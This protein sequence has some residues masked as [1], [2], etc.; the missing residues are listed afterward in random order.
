MKIKLN[1]AT[2]IKKVELDGKW[3]SVD[4]VIDVDDKDGKVLLNTIYAGV[5]KF[6]KDVEV[7]PKLVKKEEAEV[8]SDKDE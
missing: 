3:Y 6:V 8:K 1:K 7:Q 4:D 2:G 5:N